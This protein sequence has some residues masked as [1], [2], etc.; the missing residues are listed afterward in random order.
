M[1]AM[2]LRGKQRKSMNIMWSEPNAQAADPC[3]Y[4]M[5]GYLIYNTFTTHRILRMEFNPQKNLKCADI[6]FISG[7]FYTISHIWFNSICLMQGHHADTLIMQL[8]CRSYR[9]SAP[10]R[11]CG[12][13][14]LHPARQLMKDHTTSTTGTS[15]T[16]KA[17][18]KPSCRRDPSSPKVGRHPAPQFF[19]MIFALIL[20]LLP[21]I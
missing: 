3:E 2:F 14:S 21:T 20:T 7:W 16:Q 4:C 8:R 1:F 19:A 15:I 11:D 12:G 17:P 18:G 9:V 13:T 5:Y 10:A 6:L